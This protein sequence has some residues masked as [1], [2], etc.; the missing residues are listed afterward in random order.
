M[1]R[2]EPIDIVPKRETKAFYKDFCA[3]FEKLE[4]LYF[5]DPKDVDK[6]LEMT[7]DPYLRLVK[8][9]PLHEA[10]SEYNESLGASEK[11]SSRTWMCVMIIAV[12]GDNPATHLPSLSFL[13]NAHYVKLDR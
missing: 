12:T 1:P 6:Y 3:A 9:E 7:H 13:H 5:G 11:N 2:V 8:R 10:L 4:D